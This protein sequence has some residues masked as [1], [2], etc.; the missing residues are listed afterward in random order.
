MIDRPQLSVVVGT[1]EGWPYVQT[2]AET[3]LREAE[4]LN[5]EILF[6]DGSGLPVPDLAE[7]DPRMRWIQ[8]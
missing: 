2:L 5:V 1:R 4:G 3:L 6:V 7:A 8:L